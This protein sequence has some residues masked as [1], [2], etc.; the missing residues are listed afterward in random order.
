MQK[1]GVIAAFSIIAVAMV[2]MAVLSIQNI[3]PI[4]L[5]FIVFRS[6][7]IPL[8]VLLA[9]SFGVGLIFGAIVPLVKSRITLF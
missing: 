4:S 2:L 6:V 1:L 5:K 9:F 8:G 7:E 3:T